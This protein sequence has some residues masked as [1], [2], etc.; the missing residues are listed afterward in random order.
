MRSMVYLDNKKEANHLLDVL[1]KTIEALQ[2][3]D[4]FTLNQLSDQTIHTASV[5]QHTDILSVAVII[6]TLNKL[7]VRKDSLPP[8]AWNTF[9]RKFSDE[10]KEA[11]D[12]LA[13]EDTEEFAR[14]LSHAKELLESSGGKQIQSFIGEIMKKALINKASKVY[15]HGISLA[16]T[17]RLF[18]LSPWELMEYVG[19]RDTHDTPYTATIDEKKRAAR[20]LAFFT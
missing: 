14:H 3:A 18:G 13:Q 2:R 16:H 19:Q 5:Q 4:V 12:N 8:K 6:Y 10:L 11:R 17:A 7:V 9:V 15:E 1:D 20:A